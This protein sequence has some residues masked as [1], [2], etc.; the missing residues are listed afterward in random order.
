MAFVDDPNQ[1]TDGSVAGPAP[2]SQGQVTPQPQGE[3]ANT[4]GDSSP[5]TIQSGSTAPK[6]TNKSGKAGSGMFTNIQN[7]VAKN[8][9]QATKMASAATEDFSNQA[10]EIRKAAESKQ[11][12]QTA[13]LQG[14]QTALTDANTFVGGQ[15]DQIMNPVV[16]PPPI[17][18][19]TVPVDASVPVEAPVPY[20]PSAD[21]ATR[22]QNIMG[23][24]I[25]GMNEVGN[26]DLSQQQM[27]ADILGQMSQN[28]RG[29][30]G[31]RNL[32][33]QT[34]QNR[35]QYNRGMS[36]LDQ[37][38]TTGDKDARESMI[39]GIQEAG[40]GIGQ[41]LNTIGQTSRTALANQQL[42][43]QRMQKALNDSI[44]G[45]TGALTSLEA[46]QS[47]LYDRM[48]A[49]DIG[50]SIS[51][52]DL[53][54]FGVT[55]EQVAN[56]Y[57]VDPTSFMGSR[58][59]TQDQMNKMNALYSLTGQ[60]G[61][62]FNESDVYNPQ[63]F[64][65]E[66]EASKGRYEQEINADTSERLNYLD[67]IEAINS[68]NRRSQSLKDLGVN[69]T[70][71]YGY[72]DDSRSNLRFDPLGIRGTIWNQQD[73]DNAFNRISEYF[74]QQA[75]LAR[76]DVE[77]IKAKYKYGQGLSAPEPEETE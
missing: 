68:G 15:V 67:N 41:E 31:R 28:V 42:E 49:L 71:G 6:T 12:Q 43:Q 5:S 38:I 40:E 13:A 64:L 65:D 24:N 34:F 20:Q 55:R 73:E 66:I 61:N 8:K 36:N 69:F 14:N 17:T 53:A 21:D 50:S 37:L 57:G 22:F 25:A 62:Q 76:V 29:E 48:S 10:A 59:V 51:D 77:P 16:T 54:A 35:G 45:E 52:E 9:P 74:R 63:A 19:N 27:R 4:Q 3:S 58:G 30:E 18:D 46:D 32:L 2:L 56:L 70:G 23:G 44:Y 72:D 26:L 60:E 1:K 75:E 7:Y 39:T 11:A 33:Q 47:G